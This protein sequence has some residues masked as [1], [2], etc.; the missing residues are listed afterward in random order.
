MRFIRNGVIPVFS[1]IV[2]AF[3]GLLLTGLP[4]Y[5]IVTTLDGQ[6]IAGAPTPAQVDAMISQGKRMDSHIDFYGVVLP[7]EPFFWLIGIILVA[8]FIGY[9]LGSAFKIPAAA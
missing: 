6:P 8:A 2:F 9:K 7:G 1:T 5:N 3:F 4:G